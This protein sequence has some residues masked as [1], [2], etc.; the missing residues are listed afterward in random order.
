MDRLRVQCVPVPGLR[1]SCADDGLETLPLPD[2]V[3]V[4]E[5]PAELPGF[6]PGVAPEPL[7]PCVPPWLPA[8]AE[9][10]DPEL[11]TD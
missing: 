6:V 3:E 2:A 7:L 4:P 10:V 9:P 5:W 8:W 11:G 1:S